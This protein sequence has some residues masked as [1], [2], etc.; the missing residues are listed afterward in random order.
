MIIFITGTSRGIGFYLANYYLSLGHNVFGCSRS[1]QTINHV[2]YHH[3][4]ADVSNEYNVIEI[5][6]FFVNNRI[7]LDVLINNAGIASMNLTIFMPYDI[8]KNIFSTNFYGTFLFSR[9]F[10]KILKKS[11]SPRIINFSTIAVPLNLEGEAI[12]ASSKASVEEFTK[13]LAK[14]YNPFGITVNCI[15]PS[16]IKTDLIKNISD[17]KISKLI[18]KLSIKKFGEYKDVSNVIDFFIKSESKNITG[19]IIYLGGLSK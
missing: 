14:E 1:K 2:N 5:T 9:N 18:D 15:G 19:Q 17:D 13:I 6:N 10:F 11:T 4:E 7:I 12:Y 8:V 16:P 3:F